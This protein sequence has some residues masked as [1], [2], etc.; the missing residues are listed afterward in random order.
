VAAALD[1]EPARIVMG[2]AYSGTD[3]VRTSYREARS[4]VDYDAG[5]RVARYEDILVPRVLLGD[6]RARAAFIE[7][8]L[9]PLDARR[10]G[11]ALRDAVLA[12]ADSGFRSSARAKR[13]A[14]R[15]RIRKYASGSNWRTG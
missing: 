11:A 15:W 4:L 10:G 9:G 8:L 2:R 6:A 13:P 12:Y 5:E 3:G 1:G 14:C 7:Q